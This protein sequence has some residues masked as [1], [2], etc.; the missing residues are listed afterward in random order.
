MTPK[1]EEVLVLRNKSQLLESGVR[2]TCDLWSNLYYV[3]DCPGDHHPVT[4]NHFNHGS[5]M[6]TSN[7]VDNKVKRE[8]NPTPC[9][10]VFI[11]PPTS[12]GIRK[13]IFNAIDDLHTGGL[14]YSLSLPEANLLKV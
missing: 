1:E 7:I 3:T 9:N 14:Q 6:D 12:N 2:W 8:R 10:I 11:R 5:A 4:I 13:E